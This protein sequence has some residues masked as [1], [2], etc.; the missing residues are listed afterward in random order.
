MH[1]GGISDDAK[2]MTFADNARL[3]QGYNVIVSGNFILNSPIKIFV[4]EE[5]NRIV[6]ADR[7]LDQA[8]GVVGAGGAN[9]LQARR[10]NEPHLR[11]L[12]M[13][14]TTMD[15][16]AARSPNHQRRRRAQR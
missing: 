6:I 7:R 12:G 8:F 11:V 16:A 2:V 15:V 13:K 4:L 9:Y 1:H 3:A 5:N 14:R 10:M